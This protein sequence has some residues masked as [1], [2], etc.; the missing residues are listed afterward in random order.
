MK[1][2]RQEKTNTIWPHIHMDSKN[3]VQFKEAENITVVIRGSENGGNGYMLVKGNKLGT[4]K[5]E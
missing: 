1:Y 5:D 4:L 2:M 3:R